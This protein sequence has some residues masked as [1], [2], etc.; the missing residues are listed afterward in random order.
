MAD[1]VKKQKIVK[2]LVI[3]PGA[4]FEVRTAVTISKE[5]LE[6]PGGDFPI[7]GGNFDAAYLV[8]ATV[9]CVTG[10]YTGDGAKRL[11]ASLRWTDDEP[12]GAEMEPY[13]AIAAQPAANE[14]Y[15]T[16]NHFTIYLLG[17]S[18]QLASTASGGGSGVV[19]NQINIGIETSVAGGA[20][21][22]K[23]RVFVDVYAFA[24]D[25]L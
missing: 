6:M 2:E 10:D 16:D 19:D 13:P 21:D 22:K 20:S 4:G 7:A 15:I 1:L 12:G 9:L 14:Q 5:D 25:T 11:T 24:D 3:N 23:F 18:N 17:H 8:T